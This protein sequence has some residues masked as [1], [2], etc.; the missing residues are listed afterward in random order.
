M[1][2]RHRPVQ[3]ARVTQCPRSTLTHTAYVG[4]S[5]LPLVVSL[6][7]L[8]SVDDDDGGADGGGGGECRRSVVTFL[9]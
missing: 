4:M 1:L 7:E 5:A 9:I 6:L 2:T 3:R 8:L